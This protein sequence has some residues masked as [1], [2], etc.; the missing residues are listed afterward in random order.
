MSGAPHPVSVTPAVL[1]VD[2]DQ[3]FGL[4]LKG[5]LERQGWATEWVEDGRQALSRCLKDPP[6]LVVAELQGGALDGFELLD[7]LRRLAPDLPVVVC[8]RGAG[9]QSWSDEIFRELG[10][11]A[12]LVRPVRFYRVGEVVGRLLA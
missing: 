8:T 9:V 3:Q 7:E 6:R 11:R 2:P 1:V 10:V 12:V 4:L 5:Y